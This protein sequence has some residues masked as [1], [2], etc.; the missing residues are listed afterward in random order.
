MDKTQFIAA[1]KAL[2]LQWRIQNGTIR[3]AK[4]DCPISALRRSLIPT[5]ADA[6]EL[7]KNYLASATVFGLDRA[8]AHD[9]VGAADAEWDADEDLRDLLLD[10]LNPTRES[11]HA[12]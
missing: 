9:I 10:E 1:V 4:G 3:C 5:Q 2:G 7:N 6:E 12:V 8:D 11:T